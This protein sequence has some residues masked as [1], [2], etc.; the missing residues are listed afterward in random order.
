MSS[1]ETPN[2]RSFLTYEEYQEGCIKV[3]YPPMSLK[4][5]YKSHG[6]AITKIELADI[7]PKD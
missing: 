7:E 2:P 1:S 6:F 5:F 3:G 4:A